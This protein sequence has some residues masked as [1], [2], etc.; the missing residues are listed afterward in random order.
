MPFENYLFNTTAILPTWCCAVCTSMS[1][2]SSAPLTALPPPPLAVGRGRS[3]AHN[4]D[5]PK[6]G[7]SLSLDILIS[8]KSGV[9]I[10]PFPPSAQS[11]PLSQAHSHVSI[12]R[13][14]CTRPTLESSNPIR[15]SVI[16]SL[17]RS[18]H[19]QKLER[20]ILCREERV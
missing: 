15:T 13:H 8:P 3:D 16:R 18:N 6:N 14:S 4:D 5:E 9:F 2:V 1:H 11:E 19:A 20:R 12:S 17:G 7:R 10:Q